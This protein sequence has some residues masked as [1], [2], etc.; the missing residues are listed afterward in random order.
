[1]RLA[2]NNPHNQNEDIVSLAVNWRIREIIA[3]SFTKLASMVA[4]RRAYSFQCFDCTKLTAHTNTP[5][6]VIE[7]KPQNICS[8]RGKNITWR[9]I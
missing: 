8:F 1:M 4:A 5:I 2:H 7:S 9:T 6:R 3:N